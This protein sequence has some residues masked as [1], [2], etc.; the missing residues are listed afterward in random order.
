MDKN[1][2][3]TKCTECGKQD[4]TVSNRLCGYSEEIHGTKI[5]ETVCDACEHQHLMDI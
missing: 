1:T 5:W 3:K 2:D 4:D